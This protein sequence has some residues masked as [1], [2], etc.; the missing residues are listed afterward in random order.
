[1]TR[2]FRFVVSLLR[3][4]ADENA[5]RRH[6]EIHNLQH[7]PSEWR[8]FSEDRFHSKYHRPKCC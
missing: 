8:R 6:L 5:Y 2:V 4:L 7:S 1:M 3:E